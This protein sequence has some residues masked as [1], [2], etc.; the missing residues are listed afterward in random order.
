MKYLL[1][2][3]SF[4]MGI[5]NL[6]ALEPD[7][8]SPETFIPD[9][10]VEEFYEFNGYV[11]VRNKENING[12]EI[13]RFD[14][15]NGGFEQFTDTNNNLNDEFFFI[16]EINNKL[17]IANQDKRAFTLPTFI[18]T[19]DGTT[20]RIDTLL[21][22][23]QTYRDFGGVSDYKST[24]FIFQ[25]NR[26]FSSFNM[27]KFTL[28]TWV[29]DGT[30]ENTY[31]LNERF[32]LEDIIDYYPI[33]NK[34]LVLAHSNSENYEYDLYELKTN[35]DTIRLGEFDESFKTYNGKFSFIE[36]DKLLFTHRKYN[37]NNYK[38]LW[39]TDGTKSGTINLTKNTD[40]I[41]YYADPV[42]LVEL[43][44]NYLIDNTYEIL[45]YDGGEIYKLPIGYDKKEIENIR[46]FSKVNDRLIF[47]IQVDKHYDM[48]VTDGTLDNTALVKSNMQYESELL[49]N[50]KIVEYKD[51]YYFIFKS[52]DG[53]KLYSSDSTLTNWEIV[54]DLDFIADTYENLGNQDLKEVELYNEMYQ[55]K[56][57]LLGNRRDIFFYDMKNNEI[58]FVSSNNRDQREFIKI[59][60]NSLYLKR[61]TDF[62]FYNEYKKEFEEIKPNDATNIRYYK[63][64]DDILFRDNL[65]FYADYYG[66]EFKMYRLDNTF[67]TV[68]NIET[69]PSHETN[70]YPNPTSDYLIISVDKQTSVSII[71]LTGNVV[72]SIDNYNGEGIDTSD[73]PVGVYNLILN[74][75]TYGGK[76][77]KE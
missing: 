55:E 77:V 72:L 13:W 28:N 39:V 56:L 46:L 61:Y 75:N 5:C 37:N 68:S 45:L 19:I 22:L 52:E 18:W 57:I 69:E 4:L 24:N 9:A 15:E 23:E 48:W 17:I 41:Y 47:S 49:H 2:L 6:N 74:K 3:I 27:D 36:S 14:G 63:G 64:L 16:G 50:L 31:N 7:L 26:Y 32:S 44:G 33:N 11:Y 53:I 20:D 67:K 65:Y 76:F 38:D 66:G 1:F 29:T 58:K 40:T 8:Y 51:R 42:D 54:S 59:Y 35:G 12:T 60:D 30:R 70:L 10:S 21:N 34:L 73:L 43:N 62:F 71:D 25:S